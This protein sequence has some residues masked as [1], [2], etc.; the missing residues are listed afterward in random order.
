MA[1]PEYFERV[2]QR[3][4]YR[5]QGAANFT[6]ALEIC[7]AAIRYAR[8]EKLADM[9]IN[10]LGITGI[11]AV[12]PFMRYELATQMAQNA[13]A[14]RIALVVPE[15]LM[16]PRKFAMLIVQNRGVNADA[17]TREADALKWLD[18]RA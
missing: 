13:G 9:L 1:P 3:A 16:D 12:T 10:V 11:E 6:T 7:M 18:A 4:F 2:G 14:L 8:D 5:P 17:F 15:A